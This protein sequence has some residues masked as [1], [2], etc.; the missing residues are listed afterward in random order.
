[1][2][3]TLGQQYI[4]GEKPTV[5]LYTYINRHAGAA[6]NTK[7]KQCSTLLNRLVIIYDITVP[8]NHV[9]IETYSLEHKER[10]DIIIGEEW[11]I[12]VPYVQYMFV[13]HTMCCF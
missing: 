3:V 8:S 7:Q 5:I 1:M 4:V 2:V 12:T 10:Y 9:A 6:N 13:F 11:Y